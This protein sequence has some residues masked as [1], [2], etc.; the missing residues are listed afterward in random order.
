MMNVKRTGVAIVLMACF[1][2]GGAGVRRLAAGQGVFV[3]GG[4]QLRFQLIGDEPIAGPD[5]RSV[6]NGWSVLMFKDRK[7]G[8]CYV[9]FKQVSG[10]AAVEAATCPP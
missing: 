1:L 6:V 8:I 4:D 9:A 5:G 2:G 3:P 10:I 7:L